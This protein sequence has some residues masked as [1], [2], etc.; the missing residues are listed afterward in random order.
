MLVAYKGKSKCLMTDYNGKRICFNKGQPVEISKAVYD[1][2]LQSR[3]VEVNDLVPV[4]AS[5]DTGHPHT[6]LGIIDSKK[7][8]DKKENN[9]SDHRGPGR[10]KLRK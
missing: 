1:S 6:V 4:T 7:E 10:P 5:D 9:N 3:H 8:E 2:M